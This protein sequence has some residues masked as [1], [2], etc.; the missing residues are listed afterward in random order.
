MTEQ[1]LAIVQAIWDEYVGLTTELD[2]RIADCNEYSDL[3]NLT[4]DDEA[5]RNLR[6]DLRSI[7]VKI[8]G[9]N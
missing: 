3:N 2:E 8:V 4:N 1:E 6:K 9:E 5:M 7:G